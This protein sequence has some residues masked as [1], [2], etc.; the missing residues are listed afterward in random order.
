MRSCLSILAL[1]A[2]PSLLSAETPAAPAVSDSATPAPLTL[3]LE[4]GAQSPP[5]TIADLAWLSGYWQGEG[6]GG[7]CEEV[8]GKPH[9][10]RMFGYFTLS[11]EGKLVFSEAMMLVEEAGSLVLKIKHFN[12]D[13]VGWEEKD[14]YVSFRLVQLGKREAFFHG[15]TFRRVEDDKLL[16]HLR[17][18]SNGK[19]REET[20]TFTRQSF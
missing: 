3:R 13:F 6:L 4:E 9:R 17:L 1:V 8:W 2:L 7:A 11:Q 20:F 14:K 19:S 5:A 15:L 16:I 18:T 10:D 12:P